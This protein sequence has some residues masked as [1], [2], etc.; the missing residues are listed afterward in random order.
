MFTSHPLVYKPDEAVNFIKGPQTITAP[1]LGQPSHTITKL[2]S[3][4]PS[5]TDHHNT[6]VRSTTIRRQPQHRARDDPGPQTS[7]QHRGSSSTSFA[8]PSHQHCTV[9]LAHRPSAFRS[10]QPSFADQH[11]TR[12][13]VI[14]GPQI[15]TTSESRPSRFAD[16]SQHCFQVNPGPRT[17]AILRSGQHWSTYDDSITSTTFHNHASIGSSVNRP[18]VR[19][20]IRQSG[21]RRDCPS[22]KPLSVFVPDLSACTS[23]L[24]RLSICGLS[25]RPVDCRSVSMSVCSSSVLFVLPAA[26]QDVEGVPA[27][28]PTVN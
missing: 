3:G 1:G 6:T 9:T 28:R 7:A 25:V 27:T 21:R 4:Q 23:T 10:D 14:I 16:P 8:D 20:V 11:N 19:Q 18:F 24:V 26:G 22:Y 15:I 2:R 17:I 13:G 5:S 12:S